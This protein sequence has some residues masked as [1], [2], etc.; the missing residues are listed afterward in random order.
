MIR[1]REQLLHLSAD[2]ANRAKNDLRAKMIEFIE[3]SGMNQAQLSDLLGLSMGEIEQILNGNG[4]IT[5]TTFAKLLIATDH[6][7]EI[8]P[9]QAS[10]M[11]NGMP[12]MRQNEPQNA[13]RR[14]RRDSR[15][16]FVPMNHGEMVD[17]FPQPPRDANG[18]PL[19]IPCDENGVP[20]PPPPH[21]AQRFGGMPGIR[22]RA[23]QAPAMPQRQNVNPYR[24]QR[25]EVAPT[26]QATS[27]DSMD[28]RTLVNIISTNGW[29]EE[30]DLVNSTRSELIDFIIMKEGTHMAGTPTPQ[31]IDEEPQPMEQEMPQNG[32]RSSNV[33]ELAR[34]LAEQLESNP[35]L[36]EVIQRYM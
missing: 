3:V 14:Q 8:K 9:L 30:I 24:V 23:E 26:R 2:W 32:Q 27:L 18:M 6:V 17:G 15:G 28:R 29:G 13:Q 10:P 11:A 36:R 22:R 21:F 4:E 35:H 34:M 19:P 1:N 25:E 7:L 20:L 31:V 33:G 16:R 12:R 5:I